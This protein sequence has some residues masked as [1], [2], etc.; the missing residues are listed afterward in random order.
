VGI[1][2]TYRIFSRVDIKIGEPISMEAYSG[3]K[4]KSELLAQV[5]DEVVPRVAALTK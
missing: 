5:M 3:Q 1:S 2:G 4:I